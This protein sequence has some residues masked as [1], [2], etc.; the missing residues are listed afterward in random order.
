MID[1][2]IRELLELNVETTKT[3]KNLRAITVPKSGAGNNAKCR[4][5]E[6]GWPRVA[7]C[8]R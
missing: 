5:V 7:Q 8:L 4:L 6:S 2:F 1:V 3:K